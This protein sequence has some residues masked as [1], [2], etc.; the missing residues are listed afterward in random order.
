[1]IGEKYNFLFNSFPESSPKV[2]TLKCLWDPQPKQSHDNKLCDTKANYKSYQQ[3]VVC[4]K[5][6]SGGYIS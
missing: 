3:T 4:L 6:I 1:M 5:A 2:L